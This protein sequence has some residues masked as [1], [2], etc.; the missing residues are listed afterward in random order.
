MATPRSGQTATLLPD[1]RV[2]IVGGDDKGLPLASAE[3]YDPA[4][5]IF[6][7]TGSLAN[8]RYYHS[9]TLLP[10]GQV[11]IA[12]GQDGTNM[13][14]LYDPKTGIFSPTGSMITRRLFQ[15]AT[16]L[17]DGRVLVAC[18]AQDASVELYDP[19]AGTFSE[20]GSMKTVIQRATATLLPDGRVLIAGG[21]IPAQHMSEIRFASTELYDPATGTFSPTG[22]MAAYRAWDNAT[23]LLDG[24]VLV[25]GGVGGEIGGASPN[26]SAELYDP[27]T[28]TFSS[29]GSMA[30][31]HAD[32]TA[33][34]LSDG[35]VLIAGADDG[36][37]TAELYDPKTGTFRATGSMAYF[38]G[39]ATAT[40]LPDGRVL[41]AGGEGGPTGGP[42]NSST[43]SS[44]EL[45]DPKSGT[46]SLAGP[47]KAP[48]A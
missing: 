14:E 35:R 24:R 26:T 17:P 42:L 13:A 43:L 30:S 48:G 37:G 25:D 16:L 12:G 22:S 41:I 11:L 40:L 36:S 18:G 3:L 1:G 9:A 45:Y 20:T 6:S 28:G 44:A 21:E 47:I 4:T 46:F 39:W 38:R 5:G 23:L 2:L 15:S 8:A 31:D 34:L 32:G 33:T 29:T 10:D 7:P 27:S 19:K